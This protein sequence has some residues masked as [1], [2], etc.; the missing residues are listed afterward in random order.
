MDNADQRIAEDARLFCE[1]ALRIGISTFGMVANLWVF[2]GV[3]WRNSGRHRREPRV[4]GQRQH[5]EG[6][7]V[8]HRRRLAIFQTA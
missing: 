7:L 5:Q 4:A 6:Y 3:L 2:T 8:L 1:A